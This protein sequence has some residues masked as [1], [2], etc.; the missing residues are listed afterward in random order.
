MSDLN[1]GNIYYQ[2]LKIY[3]LNVILFGTLPPHD[4]QFTNPSYLE[5]CFYLPQIP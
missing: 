3:I 4:N 2:E 5:M 1:W